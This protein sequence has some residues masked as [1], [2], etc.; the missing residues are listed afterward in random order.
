MSDVSFN[1]SVIKLRES[2]PYRNGEIQVFPN[3]DQE[4]VRKK[5][6]WNGGENDRYYTVRD[7]D[8]LDKIAWSQ[9][10]DIVDKPE[11]YYWVIAD[12]NEIENPLDLSDYIG[13]EIVIPDIQ[14][15]LLTSESNG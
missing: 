4:L 7:T 2:N 5:I 1:N 8:T 10:K 11:W 14:L 13:D 9:Y 6:I 3:G 12:A 15:F